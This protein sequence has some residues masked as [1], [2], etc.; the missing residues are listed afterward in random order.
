M[1]IDAAVGDL[2]LAAKS[3]VLR[4]LPSMSQLSRDFYSLQRDAYRSTLPASTQSGAT[5]SSTPRFDSQTDLDA[6]NRGK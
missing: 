4:T 1:F 5:P 6:T 2:R 3:P